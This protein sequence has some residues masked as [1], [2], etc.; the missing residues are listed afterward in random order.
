MSRS[1]DTPEKGEIPLTTSFVFKLKISNT[2]LCTRK[3]KISN[4][5]FIDYFKI[6]KVSL[7]IKKN[8]FYIYFEIRQS[9]LFACVCSN[10]V[11]GRSDGVTLIL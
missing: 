8:S 2:Q 11:I 9:T 7:L 5:K 4:I 6:S 3:K 10:E 1:P